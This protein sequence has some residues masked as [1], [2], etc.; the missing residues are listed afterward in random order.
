M[1]GGLPTRLLFDLVVLVLDVPSEGM[2]LRVR[3]PFDDEPE[4]I[5]PE[6]QIVREVRTP[7]QPVE[8]CADHRACQA[9]SEGLYPGLR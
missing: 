9:S 6:S 3:M 7:L 5:K 4:V 2:T 8:D 1:S